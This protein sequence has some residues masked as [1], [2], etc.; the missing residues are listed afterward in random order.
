MRIQIKLMGIGSIVT[1]VAIT[2]LS[3]LGAFV[4]G[5]ETFDGTTKDVAT[6]NEYAAAGAPVVTQNNALFTSDTGAVLYETH[7]QLIDSDDTVRV[8]ITHTGSGT[9]S[10]NATGLILGAGAAN[11][12][13]P[14]NGG[15]YLWLMWENNGGANDSLYGRARNGGSAVQSDVLA[16]ANGLH[17]TNTTYIYEIERGVIDASSATFRLYQ[18]D[19]VTL[20]DETTLDWA[21]AGLDGTMRIILYGASNNTQFDNVMINV[22]PEPAALA[23]FA[24]AG[25]LMLRRR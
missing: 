11:F 2:P 8:S 21:F 20:I 17:P 13:Y 7:S 23:G 6:W 12:D 1:A 15:A 16:P 5:V 25:M 22:I 3:V 18:S 24:V 14:S 19:G 4:S 10:F 9:T